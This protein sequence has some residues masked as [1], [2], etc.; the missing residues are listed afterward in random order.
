LACFNFPY[1][2]SDG[3]RFSRLNVALTAADSGRSPQQSWMPY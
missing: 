3:T 2:A 1:R